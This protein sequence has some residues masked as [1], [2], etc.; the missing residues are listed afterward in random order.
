ML[1]RDHV[2]AFSEKLEWA[3]RLERI[4]RVK[5]EER[6]KATLIQNANSDVE[7][8][9]QREN[10]GKSRDI[11]AKKV[12]LVVEIL[13]EKPNS[14]L[15]MSHFKLHASPTVVGAKKNPSIKYI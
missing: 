12:V 2:A 1:R 9:P 4:E 14:S 11:V 7:N 8:F 15:N 6:R 3:R 5:A 13:M 10:E